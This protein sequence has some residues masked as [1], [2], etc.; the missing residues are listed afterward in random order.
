MC[1]HDFYVCW[2]RELCLEQALSDVTQTRYSE[3]YGITIVTSL[4]GLYASHI[5]STVL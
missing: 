4:S 5:V 2:T 3:S 1:P